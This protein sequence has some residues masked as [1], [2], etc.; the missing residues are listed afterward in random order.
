MK[1]SLVVVLALTLSG[2]ASIEA[3]DNAHPVDCSA[4]LKSA[5]F[6]MGDYYIVHIDRAKTDHFGREWVRPTSN[7]DLNISGWQRKETFYDYHCV[8]DKQ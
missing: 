5:S 7:L 6:G 8:N 4:R 2:C 3:M 1:K